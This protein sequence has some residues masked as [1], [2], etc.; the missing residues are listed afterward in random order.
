MQYTYTK[1]V[2]SLSERISKDLTYIY[3]SKSQQCVYVCVCVR[4]YIYI[5]IYTALGARLHITSSNFITG[6]ATYYH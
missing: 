3:L 1:W 2:L 4:A 5:Y 6:Y